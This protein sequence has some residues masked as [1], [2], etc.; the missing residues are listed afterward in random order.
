M[1]SIQTA[2]PDTY[3][4]LTEMVQS[5]HQ[6]KDYRPVVV[7]VIADERGRVLLVRSAKHPDEWMLPQ[8]GIDEG[9]DLEVAL[10]R[11]IKEET[12]IEKQQ[13]SF[14]G[15]AGTADLDAEAGRV[16]KRGFIKGKRYIAF[17]LH[18][19]GPEQVTLNP[20]EL[21]EHRWVDPE[22]VEQMLATTR[23]GKRDLILQFIG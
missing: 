9:E 7:A 17:S 1:G 3:W 10:Y 22:D 15:F 13:L 14:V 11:E 19:V 16:D 12:G 5:V 18:Y 8:G 2:I 6:E 20:A 21:S 23:A 4:L